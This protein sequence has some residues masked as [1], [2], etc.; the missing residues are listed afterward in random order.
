MK[1]NTQTDEIRIY[2]EPVSYRELVKEGKPAIIN[3]IITQWQAAN[4]WNLDYFESISPT[5]KVGVKVG[6]VSKG[7]RAYMQMDEYVQL[8]KKHER[9]GVQ[10]A[11]FPPYL[12]DVPIFHALPHLRKDIEPFP[13][14]F[15]PA[16][17]KKDFHKYIQFFMSGTGSLTPLHFD[18]LGTNNMFFQVYGKKKFILISEQDRNN[19]Y[20]YDWRW[21]KVNPQKPDFNTFP[22]FKNVKTQEVIVNPGQVLYIPS[23]TL[24]QVETLTASISFN[25]D[26]HTPGSV[27]KSLISSLRGAPAKNFYY[28]LVI[29]SGLWFKIPSRALFH[30]YKTYLNYIS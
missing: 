29:A 22:L 15:F 13:T 28:N 17:Y 21:A 12:H 9:N 18:T 26:W 3:N 8:L 19:C 14:Q 2:N 1:L 24:H 25:I 27:A 20:L 5:I 30:Y 7:N 16:L 11:Q 6:D 23:F 4:S 10:T